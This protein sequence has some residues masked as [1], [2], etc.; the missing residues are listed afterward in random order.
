MAKKAISPTKPRRFRFKIFGEVISELR[1]VVWP[2][3]EEA[4]RL[5]LFVLALSIA[6]G[7][8]LGAIDYGFTEL[9]K[10]FLPR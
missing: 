4:I 8:L 6:L 10:L 1:K 5:A 9:T 2:T 3:K 7:L